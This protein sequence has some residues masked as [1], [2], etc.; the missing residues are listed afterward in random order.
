MWITIFN[1]KTHELIISYKG[2]VFDEQKFIVNNNYTMTV[3]EKEP[4]IDVS[5]NIARF[6][7]E[8]CK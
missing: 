8:V 1:N 4:L 5:D 3:S 6:Y 7:P 2:E